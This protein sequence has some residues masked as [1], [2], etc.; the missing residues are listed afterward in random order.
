MKRILS[1]FRLAASI[2]LVVAGF[3]LC[4][5]ASVLEM[6]GAVLQ[7]AGVCMQSSQQP[8]QDNSREWCGTCKSFSGS[9]S[10]NGFC[11]KHNKP[12]H[13]GG[14][15]TYWEPSE[16]SLYKIAE[17]PDKPLPRKPR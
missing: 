15:C 10:K 8:P 17:Q 6:I 16:Q 2:S 11:I 4:A 12:E 13:E 7:I 14:W 5:V 1:P 9:L 3:A